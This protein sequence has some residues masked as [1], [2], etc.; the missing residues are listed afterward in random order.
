[1]RGVLDTNV[2]LS[3]IFFGGVPGEILAAWSRGRFGVVVSPQVLD[4]Y[5][6]SG[7]ALAQGM[8]LK[9]V[10]GWRGIAVL[11]PKRFY[12]EFVRS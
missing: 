12:D 7:M 11:P 1:M 10:S 2:V 4:E 5:A 6:R 9:A 3:G 8:P